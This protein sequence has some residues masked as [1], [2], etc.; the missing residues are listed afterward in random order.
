MHEPCNHVVHLHGGDTALLRERAGRFLG[1]GLAAGE[2]A[3]VIAAPAHVDAF[4]CQLSEDGHDPIG[5]IRSGRLALVDAAT[6]LADVM[7]AGSLDRDAFMRSVG[8]T[9]SALRVRSGVRRLRAYGEMV[10]ILWQAR[11]YPDAAVLEGY[12]NEL[13]S[14]EDLSLFCGYPIDLLDAH[15]DV[16]AL[17][18]LLAAHTV[19]ESNGPAFDAALSRAIASVLGVPVPGAELR[20]GWGPA[21]GLEA[22]ALWLREAHPKRAGEVLDRAVHYQSSQLR[23]G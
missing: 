10:G 22:V 14:E 18:P 7:P 17:R 6:M 21:T 1:E 23:A 19:M 2:A 3:L 4:I 12:W 15:L 16:E 20:P 8:G 11:R 13:L 5:A 9:L